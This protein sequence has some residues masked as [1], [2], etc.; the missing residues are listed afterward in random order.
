VE[1]R[2]GPRASMKIVWISYII[3]SFILLR[4]EGDDFLAAARRLSISSQS[5]VIMILSI[6]EEFYI[7]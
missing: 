3:D 2:G 4:V 7:L 6:T 1:G 5:L